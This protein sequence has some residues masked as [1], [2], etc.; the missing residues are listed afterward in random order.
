MN[1]RDEESK[2]LFFIFARL[3]LNLMNSLQLHLVLQWTTK[4]IKFQHNKCY[5]LRLEDDERQLPGPDISAL[6]DDLEYLPNSDLY[7]PAVMQCLHYYTELMQ[8][9][10]VQ[11]PTQ[12]YQDPIIT[13]T[14]PRPT[15][16]TTTTTRKTTTTTT[17]RSTTKTKRT[18]TTPQTTKRPTTT[19]S[20]T[21]PSTSPIEL[22]YYTSQ[23]NFSRE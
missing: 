9:E 15:T 22:P 18:T 12:P 19:S 13:T 23:Q 11:N 20:V 2:E 5:S 3:M 4:N 16:T 7:L 14:R 6:R 21:M 10:M 8:Y 1:T 17:T